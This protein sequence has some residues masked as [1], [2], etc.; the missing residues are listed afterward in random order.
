[1]E[2][3][4]LF[5]DESTMRVALKNHD[6]VIELINVGGRW[7]AEDCEA[8]VERAYAERPEAPAPAESDC[9]CPADL[10]AHLIQSLATGA[11]FGESPRYRRWPAAVYEYSGV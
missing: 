1:M 5:K 8:V 2:C 9:V 7:L 3:V 4:T 11:G 6:D 10:A